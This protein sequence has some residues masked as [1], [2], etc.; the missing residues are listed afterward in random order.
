M[1]IYIVA[2]HDYDRDDTVGYFTDIEK[3]NECCEYLNKVE[4]SYY[5]DVGCKWRVVTYHPHKTN[6]NAWLKKLKREEA[7]KRQKEAEKSLQIDLKMFERFK[8]KFGETIARKEMNFMNDTSVITKD[9]FIRY[10][11]VQASGVC[12]MWSSEVQELAGLTKEDHMDIIKN[13]DSY[14]KE[15]DVHVEDYI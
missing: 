2:L 8:E 9:K 5:A 15:F 7:I 4:T 13:Y 10:V 12:N 14:E 3:A 11:E 6:Y 1:P